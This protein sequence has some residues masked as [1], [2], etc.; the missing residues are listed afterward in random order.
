MCISKQICNYCV[1]L[2]EIDV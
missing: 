1:L 2:L